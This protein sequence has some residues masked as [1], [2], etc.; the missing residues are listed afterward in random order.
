MVVNVQ[1]GRER[2]D[3]SFD[4]KRTRHEL[5]FSVLDRCQVDAY[6]A[7]DEPE[8][9]ETGASVFTRAI[10]VQIVQARRVQDIE[11]VHRDS[12]FSI[13]SVRYCALCSPTK[14]GKNKW[15]KQHCMWQTT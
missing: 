5:E 14:Y 1:N 4:R 15:L 3:T 12:R 10:I 11:V 9:N 2:D 6:A 7:I 13:S 8:L